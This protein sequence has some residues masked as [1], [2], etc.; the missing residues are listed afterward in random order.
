[1]RASVAR[2]PGQIERL[3]HRAL[4]ARVVEVLARAE[5]H[6]GVGT[7]WDAQWRVGILDRV[8]DRGADEL[9]AGPPVG[10]ELGVVAL[11]LPP[12]FGVRE[13]TSVV[14]G[15]LHARRDVAGLDDDDAD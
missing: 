6:L 13:R 7:D 10:V 1:M 15:R 5:D 14:L 12:Q 11:P 3:S 8:G 4:E 9:R 2:S